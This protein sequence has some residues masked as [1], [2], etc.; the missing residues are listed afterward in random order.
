MAD[1]P[2]RG[3]G[4][5]GSHQNGRTSG[6]RW[7][8]GE[9]ATGGLA[10]VRLGDNALDGVGDRRDSLGG[11]GRR[12]R[13]MTSEHTG[14][15]GSLGLGRLVRT[16]GKR[17][18]AVPGADHQG[19]DARLGASHEALRNHDLQTQGQQRQDQQSRFAP[20][21]VMALAAHESRVGPATAFVER[22]E[23]QAAR[24]SVSA[25]RWIAT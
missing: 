24:A 19:W 23:V 18:G 16:I 12:H 3:G 20:N 17:K 9:A 22:R 2:A 13:A 11:R 15:I 7:R 21:T 4:L 14:G 5:D 6:G 25:M 10:N 8:G 1:R